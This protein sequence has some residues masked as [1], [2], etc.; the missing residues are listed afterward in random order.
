MNTDPLT[1]IPPEMHPWGLQLVTPEPSEFG[2]FHLIGV[3]QAS[4]ETHHQVEVID[5]DGKP[6]RGVWVIFGWD[7]GPAINMPVRINHWRDAPAVLRGNAQRT[8][9]MGYAQHTFGEGG[10][11]IW[12]WD[13]NK[14]G[15]LL[16][17]SAIVKNCTWQRTPVANFEHTG[18]AISFQL[19]RTGVTPAADRLAALEAWV[20]GLDERLK[21]V[22]GK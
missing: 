19:K 13:R 2:A 5:E 17:P 16:Y 7:T 14:D 15:D 21:A 3:E 9:A 22:E 1:F 12:I 8:N 6:M 10:E 4:I 18:V 11:D 20:T